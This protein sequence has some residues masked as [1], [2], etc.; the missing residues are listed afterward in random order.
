[1]HQYAEYYNKLGKDA[2]DFLRLKIE[3]RAGYSKKGD[4]LN[5]KLISPLIHFCHIVV[6]YTSLSHRVVF[7]HSLGI[8]LVPYIRIE[9]LLHEFTVY[10]VG[11]PQRNRIK[12][13]ISSRASFFSN[14]SHGKACS[15][16]SC[17]ANRT[18]FNY[19]ENIQQF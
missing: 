13:I 19:S 8:P 10:D 17:L 18:L 14:A 2:R 7:A 15:N 1:V 5:N 11:F 4:G 3:N 16:H 12:C 6:H 9:I